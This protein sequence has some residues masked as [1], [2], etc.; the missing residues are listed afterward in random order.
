TSRRSQFVRYELRAP[1]TL[2]SRNLSL[3][4]LVATSNP[5]ERRE[6]ER[7]QYGTKCQIVQLRPNLAHRVEWYTLRLC[8]ST[9]AS[10]SAGLFVASS[11]K[12][13]CD[14]SPT[15]NSTRSRSTRSRQKPAFRGEPSSATSPQR[16]T[17]S[18]RSLI[19]GQC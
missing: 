15:G 1:T 4:M 11:R 18:L 12:S 3:G 5:P 16:K 7:G 17:S 9:S 2:L 8:R 6:T 10:A 13:R 19:S 14:C